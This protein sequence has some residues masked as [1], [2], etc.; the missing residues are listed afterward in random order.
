MNLTTKETD[1]VFSIMA[2]LSYGYA[3]SELRRRVG[4]KLLDLL[5]AQYF[6]SYVWNTAENAFCERVSI[7]MSDDNLGAYEQHFQFCDPIT[8]VLQRRRKATCVSEIMP[9]SRFERTEF[10]NDFLANDGLHYGVNYYAYSGGTN[11][12]DLRIWRGR[13]K[14]DFSHRELDILNAI[15]PA[16]T[17][18]M[19]G[20]MAREKTTQGKVDLV[21]ALE[22][23]ANG[24][25]LTAREKEIC[26]AVL[27]G[28]SDQQIA[29]KYGISFTTVRSHIKHIYGKLGIT[30]RTQL[31]S[32]VIMH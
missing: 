28:L 17:N 27:A 2:D 13:N 31:L 23:A 26:A 20:A 22:Q 30:G 1:L 19:R 4:L 16:F 14:E 9:R 6:A 10:F 18:A 5:D 32:R 21:T 12:G 15:G 7:N 3:S 29:T 24:A 8:P 25:M 11:I